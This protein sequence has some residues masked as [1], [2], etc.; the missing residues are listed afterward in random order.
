[1]LILLGPP[2]AGKGTQAQRLVSKYGLV[3]LS[4]GEMLRGAAASG[5]PMGMQ[6][7]SLIDQGRLVPD[8]MIV[9]IIADRLSEADAKK[10]FI[11]DGF[12]RTVPQAKALD[13]LLSQRRLKIDAVIE[14]KVHEGILLKRIEKRVAQ[15]TARGATLRSDDNPQVLRGRLEAYRVQ[16]APLAGYYRDKGLLKSVDGMA[17]VDEVTAAINRALAPVKPPAKRPRRRK[18]A[19]RRLAGPG[20]RK[21]ARKAPPAR[22]KKKAGRGKSPSRRRLT[23]A[24]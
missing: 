3:H 16:T 2:G 24:R 11:L 15:M 21:T 19:P 12:P 4:S 22:R 14:L 5:T 10:G 1:M 9:S 6:I 23:K 7:K 8:E 20:G 17:P 13:R 18:A